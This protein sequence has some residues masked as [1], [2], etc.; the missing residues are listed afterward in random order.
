MRARSLIYS[1]S[2]T[3]IGVATRDLEEWFVLKQASLLLSARME[4]PS[5][6]L[7][8]AVKPECH[9]LL[10]LTLPAASAALHATLTAGQA[11]R[12]YAVV[13]FEGPAP[14]FS[15]IRSVPAAVPPLPNAGGMLGGRPSFAA[16]QG[17]HDFVFDYGLAF[18]LRQSDAF[19]KS[20]FGCACIGSTCN[21]KNPNYNCGREPF[22]WE[23]KR[24][25]GGALICPGAGGHLLCL[26]CVEAEYVGGRPFVTAEKGCPV[27]KEGLF[28]KFEVFPE[29]GELRKAQSGEAA[30]EGGHQFYVQR[31]DLAPCPYCTEPKGTLMSGVKRAFEEGPAPSELGPMGMLL[32]LKRSKV[33]PTVVAPG[34]FLVPQL[35]ATDGRL[36]DISVTGKGLVNAP[37]LVKV[38]HTGKFVCLCGQRG[39]RD[40]G[41]GFLEQTRRLDGWWQGGDAD[42]VAFEGSRS[43]VREITSGVSWVLPI[44]QNG[45]IGAVLRDSDAA[46][47]RGG[48][49]VRA[50]V[51]CKG[52]ERP[53]LCVQAGNIAHCGHVDCSGPEQCRH[54][55]R[56]LSRPQPHDGSLVA[57]EKG[58]QTVNE[59][60]AERLLQREAGA[61]S[62]LV[63]NHP[64]CRRPG[65]KAACTHQDS[66]EP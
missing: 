47:W 64:V 28:T 54:L 25:R 3:V 20:G 33:P 44:D 9:V 58:Q 53:V 11:V 1:R 21:G 35:G 7:Q 42:F 60:R 8:L 4:L 24:N 34:L 57:I 32:E 45:Q 66:L 2:P 29:T 12:S 59:K 5:T 19:T 61:R 14:D 31:R 62:L 39:C 17:G 22:I 49:Q 63:C 6:P 16:R 40:H 52:G 13:H 26:R 46:A 38:D 48:R 41:V 65:F 23:R 30:S 27:G 43:F 10:A 50:F 18:N 55:S 36:L 37:R 56:V 15:N 51:V